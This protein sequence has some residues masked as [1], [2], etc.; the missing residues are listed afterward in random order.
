MGRSSR[1]LRGSSPFWRGCRLPTVGLPPL[2][3]PRGR[4]SR[5]FIC[6]QAVSGLRVRR[7]MRPLARGPGPVVDRER[8]RPKGSRCDSL[9]Q[10]PHPF[11]PSLST[12]RWILPTSVVSCCWGQSC[13]SRA[14]GLGHRS[15]AIRP[16]RTLITPYRWLSKRGPHCSKGALG[17]G[18]WWR[19]VPVM[20]TTWCA[21]GRCW[22]PTGSWACI[23]CSG[24]RADPG[25]HFLIVKNRPSDVVFGGGRDKVQKNSA[26]GV[27]SKRAI[28][29]PLHGRR[30]GVVSTWEW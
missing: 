20:P 14:L 10:R 23:R 21:P 12:M 30:T 29:D 1:A 28:V 16:R 13:A 2:G 4:T 5:S 3:R 7:W 18:G 11:C 17:C 26:R 9:S 8:L 6:W 22:L 19:G 25:H 24:R 15:G 27:Q